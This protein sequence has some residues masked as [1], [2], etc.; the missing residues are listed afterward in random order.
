MQIPAVPALARNTKF[1]IRSG[2]RRM[3]QT[4]MYK[5]HATIIPISMIF[6]ILITPPAFL[7]LKYMHSLI[8]PITF[9][10]RNNHFMLINRIIGKYYDYTIG[11][12]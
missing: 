2:L 5:T 10:Y 11:N 9:I 7:N 12:S 4:P 1:K 8:Q 3:T 6:S